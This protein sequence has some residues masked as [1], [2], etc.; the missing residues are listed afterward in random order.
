MIKK[1]KELHDAGSKL[2]AELRP[3]AE[4]HLRDVA[5]NN[6]TVA[7]QRYT[8]DWRADRHA[9]LCAAASA[10]VEHDAPVHAWIA[11]AETLTASADSLTGFDAAVRGARFAPAPVTPLDPSGGNS[12]EDLL[13]ELLNETRT[14]RVHQQLAR[15]SD[16]QLAE[17]ANTALADDDRALAREVVAEVDRR[18]DASADAV[19]AALRLRESIT[20]PE[21]VTELREQLGEIERTRREIAAVV[22]V[23]ESGDT[24]ELER[25]DVVTGVDDDLGDLSDDDMH[26]TWR[27]NL[28]DATDAARAEQAETEQAAAEESEA[29]ANGLA[30]DGATA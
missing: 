19:G 28:A 15:S 3:A 14:Q 18:G 30:D 22:R 17:L 29:E 4:K 9:K 23:L 2:L 10:L 13:S 21:E 20:A 11:Q 16:S 24:T 27:E 5:A 6:S 12:F 1:A 26:A 8:D 7:K 25:V